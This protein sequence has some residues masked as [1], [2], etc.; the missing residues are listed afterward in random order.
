MIES[1]GIKKI[2]LT[3]IALCA[4]LALAVMAAPVF[5]PPASEEAA[6]PSPFA[7]MD[8][9]R[10][11]FDDSRVHEINLLIKP[12]NW[13]YMVRHAAEEQYVVCDVEVDG[14]LLREVALRP[15]GNSS[16]ASIA[17]QGSD[18][19]SFKLEFDHFRPDVTYHGLDK[20]SL[21]N[22]GQDK[23][24][25]KDYLTYRMMRDMD[26]PGPL[27]AYTLLRV[28]GEPFGLYLAVEAVEDSFIRR[29]YG[30]DRAKL[31]RPDVYD[32]A[33]I[34]PSAFMGAAED[35]ALFPDLSALGPGDRVDILGPIINLAFRDAA[36]QVLLSAGGYAGENPADYGVV[37]DTAVFG[38]T[39]A[40]KARYIQAVRTLNTEEN[41]RRAL[42]VDSLARYFAVH[43]FVNNYD[44][45]N[46]IFVHNFYLCELDG[47]L[48]LIPWDYNLAFGAFSAESAYKSFF[49]GTAYYQEL[50]MGE[51]MS[52]EKSFVNYP[53]DTPTISAALE[54]RPLLW[55]LLA[56]EEGRKLCHAAY[57]EL[58]N[59]YFRGEY[60]DTLLNR[61][62][63]LIRPYVAQGLAFY[64]PEEFEAGA[65]A[66]GEYCRLRAESIDGQ[67]KGDI[68]ATLEGQRA[69][70]ETLV[71]PGTLDLSRTIDF[72]GLAFGVTQKDLVAVLDAVFAG[73]APG[74]DMGAALA[75]DL[76]E[77]PGLLL[78]LAARVISASP[79]LSGLI[80]RAVMPYVGLA[81]SVIALLLALRW[82]KRSGRRLRG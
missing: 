58:L 78:P 48:S 61:A 16:L 8:Y 59:L 17:A 18:R 64:T 71:D 67:L 60:F 80:G 40:D 24:C 2:C 74:P 29:A 41:P 63:E 14:E 79:L 75:A 6:A 22:L 19:F 82:V 56:D 47:R 38:V 25:L 66:V 73:Y 65:R 5:L 30:N 27:C 62:V 10:R 15:K 21:N 31:Y 44:S 9:E 36:P 54:D 68:P 26:V 23:S 20:I 28:N 50:S 53:I 46:S 55:A 45:Y 32:I 39:E 52:S 81:A 1:P 76:Q 4:A 51:A 7:A 70:P 35:S 69:H 11:L 49:Q 72:G 42:D 37:F 3:A 34:T 57:E 13:D 77:N 43:H 12:V 33:T